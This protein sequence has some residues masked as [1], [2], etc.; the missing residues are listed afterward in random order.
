MAVGYDGLLPGE[1]KHYSK[2]YHSILSGDGSVTLLGV[3]KM[4]ILEKIIIALKYDHIELFYVDF[5]RINCAIAPMFVYAKKKGVLVSL[6][7]NITLLNQRHID[8]FKEYPVEVI[9]TS[10]YG[11]SEE[12]Y[13]KVTGVKGS[14][15]KFMNALELLQKNDIKYELK[16]VAM[17]QNIDD[18]YK[19]RDF[20]NKLGVP[21]VVILDVHPMS[22]GSMEPVS[23]RLTPEAAF[24]FDVQDNP[25]MDC[26]IGNSPQYYPQSQRWNIFKEI[27]AD[28]WEDRQVILN[29]QEICKAFFE[30][31]TKNNNNPFF[32]N[33][34]RDLLAAILI[35]IVRLGSESKEFVKENFYNN[36]I[37]EFLDSSSGTDL[38]D[39]L[40][41]IMDMR[42]VLSY[43]EGDS[44]QS[45]GVLAEM[46]SVVRD[47]FIGVFAEKGG[48]SIRNFVVVK[49]FCNTT[50]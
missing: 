19:V 17:E 44:T 13:E 36:R 47:I 7:S 29:T 41:G 21:M 26:V 38:C 32:P 11:Y 37:K 15:R 24:D 1:K 16:F 28:G 30:E 40:D 27:L 33:A 10:M 25:S 42:S 5:Q 34:A 23:F 6:L 50:T 9:S 4:D 20:G 2:I 43:I 22:D 45:Q 48:F 3:F 18:L 49:L 14:F 8:L 12:S 46:Y 39:L 35:T 31:R